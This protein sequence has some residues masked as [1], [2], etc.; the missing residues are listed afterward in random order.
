MVVR[1]KFTVVRYESTLQS[2]QLD[3]AGGYEPANYEKVE[4]RTIIMTPVSSTDPTTEN[5]Q[6][7]QQSPSGEIRLGVINQQAWAE[8][9]LGKDYY[10]TFTPAK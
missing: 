2:R 9:E 8:F 6:F 7:W 5:Y 4:M 10:V 1:A 3:P